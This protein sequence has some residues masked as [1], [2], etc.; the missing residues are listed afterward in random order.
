MVLWDL[1][2][3]RVKAGNPLDCL[4]LL[5]CNMPSDTEHLISHTGKLQTRDTP[6]SSLRLS[7]GFHHTGESAQMV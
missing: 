7:R 3:A 5:D 6:R 2:L 1:Y 4:C